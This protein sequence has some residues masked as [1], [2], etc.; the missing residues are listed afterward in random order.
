M[1]RI[2]CRVIISLFYYIFCVE[3]FALQRPDLRV[4]YCNCFVL[5]TP[6]GWHV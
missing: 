4:I 5:H 6:I 2:K 1:A 3:G